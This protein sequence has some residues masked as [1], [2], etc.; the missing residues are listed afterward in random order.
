M[1]SMRSVKSVRRVTGRALSALVAGLIVLGFGLAALLASN[2]NPILGPMVSEPDPESAL[3]LELPGSVPNPGLVSDLRG[4][5]VVALTFDDG[6]DPIETPELLDVL[7]RHGVQA[8]FFVTG[9]RVAQHPGIVRRMVSEG[10]EIGLHAHTHT[11][12]GSLSDAEILRQWE[13]NQQVIVAV[14][15][16][17]PRLARL[18]FSFDAISLTADEYRAAELSQREG[19]LVVTFMDVA[20]PDFQGIG[21]DEIVERSMPRDGES[22]IITLHD[23]AGPRPRRTA[24]A[25]D[26]LIPQLRAEGYEIRTVSAYAG[27]GAFAEPSMME[28]LSASVLTVSIVVYEKV[29]PLLRPLTLAIAPIM[30]VRFVW[31]FASARSQSRRYRLR[32]P[33]R[34][35]ARKP[36]ISLIVPAYNE[37]VGI[38]AALRSFAALEYD[39]ALEVLVVDDGSTDRTA[40]LA[41]EVDGVRVL[42]KPNGGKASALNH[43]I[44]AASH[45]VCVL[46]D[47]DTVFEPDTLANIVG[48]LE[49]PEVGA[50]S[51]YPKVGNRTNLLTKIQHLEYLQGCSLVRRSQERFNMISCLPGAIGA[52]RKSALLEVDGVPEHTMAEDTDLTFT[53]GAHGWKVAYAPDAVAWTEVP[54][55]FRTFLKQRIRWTYGVYQ[56]L[57]KHRV[58]DPDATDNRY[59]RSVIA[60]TI[61]DMFLAVVSPII[62]FLAIVAL[63]SGSGGAI[64]S[65]VALTFITQAAAVTYSARL[66]GESSRGLR[67]I[68]LQLLFFRYFT[69]FVMIIAA[70]SAISGRREKWNKPPRVGLDAPGPPQSTTRQLSLV[71][72]NERNLP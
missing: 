7:D 40:E 33:R 32:G 35:R 26:R 56:V 15:G 60:Y 9:E 55:D 27:L 37:E 72:P 13:V 12:L 62:D 52:F 22:A 53:L 49:D 16:V 28:R 11:R 14:A 58:V 69:L 68:P 20:A 42:S 47:G 48:P 46:V 71:G 31:L 57:W 10:H 21:T 51:G 30:I 19:G 38:Q 67:Y 3:G 66:D 6:P 17:K 1:R 41:S 24:E 8:T 18:P 64:V 25:V 36:D 5:S 29:E 50:V 4:R 65:L 23:G 45:E 54:I 34:T 39:G 70:S 63:L 61:F 59:R 2:R 44:R 43:G